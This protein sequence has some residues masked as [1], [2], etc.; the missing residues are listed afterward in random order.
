MDI[1][2]GAIIFDKWI[3][4]G[5]FIFQTKIEKK[6]L[7]RSIKGRMVNRLHVGSFISMLFSRGNWDVEW[8]K[9]III[10]ED[11]AVIKNEARM[12]RKLV[13]IP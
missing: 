4:T 12:N 10:H 1:Y 9:I 3:N 13:F 5:V 2:Y 8:D 11:K 6:L 7:I